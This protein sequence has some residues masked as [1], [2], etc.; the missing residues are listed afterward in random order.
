MC[1]YLLSDFA[2]SQQNLVFTLL[3]LKIFNANRHS[4]RINLGTKKLF[5]FWMK[6]REGVYWRMDFDLVCSGYRKVSRYEHDSHSDTMIISTNIHSS[7]DDFNW[8]S[9][10]SMQKYLIEGVFPLWWFH[11]HLHLTRSFF[12]L[13]YFHFPALFFTSFFNGIIMDSVW[14]Y[15]LV[16]VHPISFPLW[17]NTEQRE[18]ILN[19]NDA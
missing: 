14:V 7:M 16:W 4:F 3:D 8:I 10:I 12:F 13:F 11:V 5:D 18:W 19:L 1:V 15:W 9:R 6:K 2:L 17:I